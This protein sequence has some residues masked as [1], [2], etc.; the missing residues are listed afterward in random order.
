[1]KIL[2]IDTTSMISSCCVYEDGYIIGDFSINQAKCHSEALFPM[3][4]DML[5]K[6]GLYLKDIDY[7]A[8]SIGPGSFTGIRIGLTSAKTLA[9]V[10]NKGII[11]ISTL[12]AMAFGVFSEKYIVPIIDARGQ[13]LYY[14]MYINECGELKELIPPSMENIDKLIEKLKAQ[15]KELIFTGDAVNLY[16]DKLSSIEKSVFTK[17]NLNN[18]LSRNI[19]MLAKEKA[20]KKEFDDVY[21]LSPVY[22]AKSQAQRDYE[23]KAEL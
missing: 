14:A 23:L 16:K 21:T 1:M 3:I 6:L 4:C 12:K 15:R 7:F 2:A 8:I 10:L 19:A 13:R 22:I 11:G 20:N 18:C 5:D 9:Q 17:A